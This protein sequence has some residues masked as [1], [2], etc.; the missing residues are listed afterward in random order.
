MKLAGNLDKIAWTIIDKALFVFFAVVVLKLIMSSISI[1]DWGV[2]QQL[3]QIHTFIFVIIDGLALQSVIQY[4][5]DKNTAP[6]VNTV[7]MVLIL[8]ISLFASLI[9]FVFQNQIAW[10]MGEDRYL[11][12]L[13]LLPLM[14]FA[15]IPRFMSIKF[16]YRDLNY[17]NLF[18][19]NLS[20][21]GVITLIVIYIK[22]NQF[23]N[24]S[25]VFDDKVIFDIDSLFNIYFYSAIVSSAVG[26]ILTRHS[27]KFS[28]KKSITIRQI[29]NFNTPIA[30]SSVLH[31]MP[32]LLD[33]LIIQF[34]LGKNSGADVVGIYS[35][36]KMLMRGF[37]DLTSAIYGIIYPLSRKYIARGELENAKVLITKAI[38]FMLLFFIFISLMLYTGLFDGIINSI[39][40]EKYKIDSELMNLLGCVQDTCNCRN[41]LTVYNYCRYY[42]CR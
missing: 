26:Y 3:I 7:S 40:P 8:I 30:F 15:M 6:F 20:Y 1:S 41:C 10:L 22:S 42:K 16:L 13:N 19:T 17:R 29:L 39:L 2:F 12:I 11:I 27:W 31:S 14:I 38:S 35:G 23:S 34:T 24:L 21:F 28:L 9:A 32:K 36:A 18:V 37:E 4:G 33:V 5:Q 25:E